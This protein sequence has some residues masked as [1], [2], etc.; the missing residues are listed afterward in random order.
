MKIT[1]IKVNKKTDEYKD[2]IEDYKNKIEFISKLKLEEINIAHTDIKSEGESILNKIKDYDYVIVLD[3]YGSQIDSIDFAE[4][5]NNRMS[6]SVQ[7]LI[8][9]IGGAFGV[10]QI[11]KNRAN[12]IMSF[13]KMVWPHRMVYIML[14]EQIYRGFNILKNTEY[15]HQ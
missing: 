15:H 4:V 5:L 2:K 12:Y 11:V 6:D 10:D 8:F 3:E 7:N 9:V 13:G 1:I 14:L